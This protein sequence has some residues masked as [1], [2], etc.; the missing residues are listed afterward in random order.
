MRNELLTLF[1]KFDNE[2]KQFE[3]SAPSSSK[4]LMINSSM[5][6]LDGAFNLGDP[7]PHQN[8]RRVN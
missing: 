1:E 7:T 2:K 6:A 8:N 3:K 4:S 5:P